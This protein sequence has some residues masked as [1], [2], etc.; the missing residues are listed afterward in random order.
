MNIK[1][2]SLVMST[3]HDAPLSPLLDPL[4]G[5]SRLN[6]GKLGLEGHSRLPALEKGRG[7][8]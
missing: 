8:C 7:A 3:K 1:H 6:C 2:W 4:K 5:L